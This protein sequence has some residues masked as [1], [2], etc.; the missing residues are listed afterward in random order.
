M[1]TSQVLCKDTVYKNKI[2]KHILYCSLVELK[3][4][5][6][7]TFFTVQQIIPTDSTNQS[8]T[9]TGKY[10]GKI[11]CIKYVQFI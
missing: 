3:A 6:K 2:K 7:K 4:T 5:E 8:S 1:G 10:R 9:G 11:L